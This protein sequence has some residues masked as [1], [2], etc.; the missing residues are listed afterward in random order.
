MCNVWANIAYH[1]GQVAISIKWQ[2]SG[3][4]RKNAAKDD[5]FEINLHSFPVDE[6]DRKKD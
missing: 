4:R 3:F 6:A 2:I 5:S 1:W